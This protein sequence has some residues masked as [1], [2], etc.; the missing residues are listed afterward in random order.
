M[1]KVVC[2]LKLPLMTYSNP[3]RKL[4]SRIVY[5]NPWITVREDQVI[6]PDGEKG[7]YSV[8]DTRIATGVLAITPDDEL[9]LVGQYRYATDEY[10]WEIVEGGAEG[11]ED[12]LEA[13]RR[14]LREEAGL[15]AADWRRLGGDVHLSNCFSSEV[16]C[17]YVARDLREV[18]FEPEATEVLQ[19]QRLPFKECLSMVNR[20]EIKDAMSIIGI[21][22]LREDF[23]SK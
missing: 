19:L 10:S 6:R 5:S 12:P 15:V 3:W 22:R 23:G 7:I 8:V 20:G 2:R 11:D 9:Y 21:L 1:H 18:D 16:A 4:G 17:L 14:E 13:A